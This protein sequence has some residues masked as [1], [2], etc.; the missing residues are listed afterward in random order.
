MESMKC[1]FQKLQR[2]TRYQQKFFQKLK[3]KISMD[4]MLS[5]TKYIDEITELKQDLN[6]NYP[7]D[8]CNIDQLKTFNDD[9]N[10][11]YFELSIFFKKIDNLKYIYS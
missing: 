10:I 8:P 6:K 11:I 2:S 4:S 5:S 9:I 1:T 3:T 7:K